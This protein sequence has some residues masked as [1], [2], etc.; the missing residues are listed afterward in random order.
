MHRHQQAP[1]HVER[2]YH[3]PVVLNLGFICKLGIRQLLMVPLTKSIPFR[4][5]VTGRSA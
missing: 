2:L 4:V 3:T 5:E 1:A